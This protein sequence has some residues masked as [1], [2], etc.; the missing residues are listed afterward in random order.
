MAL[1][2]YTL[3]LGT[4][5]GAPDPTSRDIVFAHDASVVEDG[6]ALLPSALRGKPNIMALLRAL[7]QP[8]QTRADDNFDLYI[9]GA[10]D[11]AEGAMLDQWGDNVGEPRGQFYNDEQRRHSRRVAYNLR[12]RNVAHGVRRV[13]PAP[14]GGHAVAGL[15]AVLDV[16]LQARAGA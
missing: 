3:G 5:S 9:M 1:P 11:M 6:L 10:I 7:L 14:V 2:P 16:R 8:L 13:H 12:A 4:Q 15:P